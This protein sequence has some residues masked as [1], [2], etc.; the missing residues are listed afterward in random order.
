MIP[1][2]ALV[3]PDPA[4]AIPDPVLVI[5]DP[6]LVI[7]DP[8]LAIPDPLVAI[9]DPVLAVAASLRRP[10]E[11]CPDRSSRRWYGPH[12]S[13][14]VIGWATPLGGSLT[15][16]ADSTDLARRDA[17]RVGTMLAGKWRLDRL[18]GV[19][20]MASVYAAS[21]RNG[22]LA[23]IKLLHPEFARSASARSRFMREGYIAN[24]AGPGAVRVLDDD[25]DDDGLPFIVMDLLSGEVLEERAHRFD[26]RLPVL[27]VLWIASETL[28]TLQVAHASG[29]IHRDLKPAN[30]FWT[31]DDHLKVLDF[32]IARVAR[33]SGE[34]TMAGTIMGTLGYM[35]HEQAAGLSTDIDARTDIWAVGAIMFRLLTGESVHPDGEINELVVAATQH[36]RSVVDVDPHL[37]RNV[38][39]IVDRALQF[40]QRDRYASA[41][42]MQ[43]AI[44]AVASAEEMAAAIRPR[45]APVVVHAHA[46]TEPP[47]P[48]TAPMAAEPEAPGLATGMSDDDTL[49]LRALFEL[50]ELALLSREELL[51][52]GTPRSLEAAKLGGFRRLDKAYQHA[53][54]ALGT[55][56]IGLFW[57]VL[58]E[59]FATR[60]GLL[61]TARPP[62]PATPATMFEGGV[63][64]LGLLPGLTL[65]EF[66]EL[67]RLFRGDLDPF[68]DF[69]TFLQSSSSRLPHLVFRIDPTKPGMASHPSIS[70][71]ASVTEAVNVRT[72]LDALPTSDPALRAVLLKRLERIAT[73]YEAEIGAVLPTAGVDLGVSL[74]RILETLGTDA[75]REAMVAAKRS[76]SPIVRVEVLSALDPGGNALRAELAEVLTKGQPS[77]RI[78][79]LVALAVYQMS[80]AVP[81]LVLRIKSGSFDMLPV[82]ERRQAFATLT[83]LVPTRA[84]TISLA[85]LRDQRVISTDAH[86]LSRA[87]ACDVLGRIGRSRETRDALDAAVKSRER[88]SE[89]V[90]IAA[91][92]ALDAFDARGGGLP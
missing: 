83:A 1:D 14:T 73:G 19:G 46:D 62:L 56:H 70:I 47:P 26:G 15:G 77:E 29:I 39:A 35:A 6:A 59:G 72:M 74:L 79:R 40:E 67:A 55:A 21:H 23:A 45:R 64:M 78:D 58:P 28:A 20:G 11:A 30:L 44:L 10:R 22:A 38:T 41:K 48:D 31:T 65:E 84:E 91:T 63:R 27:E 61:W 9:P 42:A 89:R 68:T 52:R 51:Q 57:N 43:E 76:A 18:L 12:E 53:V 3:I 36:A 50:I 32:G 8:V 92:V 85:I 4:L 16:M 69:A 34:Q 54:S 2:P 33:E 17:K 49:A 75:E 71:D 80:V 25:V 5:P 81:A 13:C 86:E 88:T 87:L 24:S 7:P 82:E 37:P 66:G 90:W 60:Q